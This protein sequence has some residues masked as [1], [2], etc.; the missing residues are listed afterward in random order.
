VPAVS[1]SGTYDLR[2]R[3]TLWLRANGTPPNLALSQFKF[4]PSGSTPAAFSPVFTSMDPLSLSSVGSVTSGQAV[5]LLSPALAVTAGDLL[6]LKLSRGASDSFG[7]PI[8]I[9]RATWE[10]TPVA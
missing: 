2:L 7:G 6:H 10:L 8:G 5:E 9:L 4:T 1:V 3:V